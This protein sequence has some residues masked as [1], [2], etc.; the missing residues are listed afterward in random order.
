MKWTELYPQTV[1]PTLEQI[2]D[3]ADS[4]L[5]REL[6]AFLEETCGSAPQLAY[7]RCGLEPGWNVK[8]KKGSRALCTV[9]LRSGYVTAMV[10]VGPRDEAAAERALLTCTEETRALYGR[11]A[12]SKMGRWLMLDVTS[13]ER[14]EDVKALLAVRMAPGKR[15]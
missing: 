4:P 12:P 2:G 9:Y 13:P 6:R 1:P 11:T 7:S 15:A 3:Y 5:W 10:S 14:L 8:Y